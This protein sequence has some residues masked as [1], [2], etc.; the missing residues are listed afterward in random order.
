MGLFSSD[1][2]NV[3]RI[4]H[5]EGDGLPGLIIDYYDGVAVMQNHS[6]GM[7]REREV[8]TS[9]LKELLGE[10]L[11]AV[12]DKS[13]GTLPFMAGVNNVNGFLLGDTGPVIV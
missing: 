8:I 2:T 1:D 12:F 13:E 6:V 9:L 5:A 10:K 11:K 7:Y 3:Y 4:V